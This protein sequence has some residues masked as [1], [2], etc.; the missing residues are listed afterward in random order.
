LSRAYDDRTVESNSSLE[1]SSPKAFKKRQATL[2]HLAAFFQRDPLPYFFAPGLLHCSD[3][4]KL[5][6]KFLTLLYSAVKSARM[7][8][9]LVQIYWDC[10]VF[11]QPESY[12]LIVAIDFVFATSSAV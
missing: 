9:S 11:P 2:L 1:A 7:H 6:C 4:T 10:L 8:Q 5:S 3:E 12:W